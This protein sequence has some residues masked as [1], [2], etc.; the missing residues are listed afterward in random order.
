MDFSFSISRAT[1]GGPITGNLSKVVRS[2]GRGITSTAITEL[3]VLAT[4]SV[5][6]EGRCVETPSGEPCTFTAYAYDSGQG[7][8]GDTFQISVNGGPFIGGR[9]TS[10]KI[11][12]VT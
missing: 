8:K 11:T 9:L 12:I 1:S 5:Q 2:A 3:V 10:G 4:N 6:F 7:G